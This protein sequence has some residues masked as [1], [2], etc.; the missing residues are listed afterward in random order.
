M[1]Q[2]LYSEEVAART[3]EICD[4]CECEANPL[5]HLC[6]PMSIYSEEF[7]RGIAYATS[8]NRATRII[9]CLQRAE[10]SVVFSVRMLPRLE[11]VASL[12]QWSYFDLRH[13][14]ALGHVCAT[15]IQSAL[16]REGLSLLLLTSQE[17][18]SRRR[19]LEHEQLERERKDQRL[20]GVAT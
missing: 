4:V 8:S 16:E 15:T 5:R 3:S 9:M 1:S 13:L 2:L 18:R 6:L 12:C 19:Q 20:K 14:S 17:A 11:T 10:T 7:Q